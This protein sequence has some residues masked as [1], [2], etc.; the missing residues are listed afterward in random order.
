MMDM[1]VKEIILGPYIWNKSFN[2]MDKI[3][4][5]IG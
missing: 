3:I 5:F 2:L 4:L 1:N